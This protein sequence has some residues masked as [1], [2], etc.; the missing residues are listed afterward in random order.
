MSQADRNKMM[1]GQTVKQ[2]MAP[3]VPL[4][5]DSSVSE[6]MINGFNM[7]FVERRGKIQKTDIV[8]PTEA[9]LQAA[10]TNIAQFVGRV[11]NNDNPRMDARLPDG[12]RVH[13]IIPPL[14]KQGVAVAIRKFSEEKLTPERLI[15]FGAL[16]P[17]GMDFLK[18][19]VGIE[20]NILVSGGTGSGKT[21]LL[22]VMTGMIEKGERV[23][24]IEDS[25]E[26]QPQQTHVLQLEARPPD[27]NGRGEVRIRE[28]LHSAMRLRPDRIIIGEIR[29]GE[30]LDLLQAM[31]S[32]HSGSMATVHANNP[33]DALARMETLSMYAGVDLPLFAIRAQVASAIDMVV[34]TSRF[35]D[36]S[37]KINYI[38]EI[39]PLT[40]DGKYKV[41][42]IFRYETTGLDP[43]TGKVLGR[44]VCT[45][46]VPTFA[47]YARANNFALTPEYFTD[48]PN[49]TPEKSAIKEAH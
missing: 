5:E 41:E 36:G 25:T 14:C 48:D 22:N 15:G 8:F 39:L 35:R 21:S 42:D 33:K 3:I 31:T 37:R 34:Q 7:I 26:L 4:L 23:L 13:A 44:H 11:L 20:K 29:G 47:A 10:I 45:G 28:L 38:S 18:A 12:S 16:T 2:F 24:V 6:I 40:D 17:H 46:Y 49:W 30:A 9:A 43:E 1:F 32:G 19:C 27:K